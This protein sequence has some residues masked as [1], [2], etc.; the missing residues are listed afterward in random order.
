MKTCELM[1]CCHSR[2]A[3]YSCANDMVMG[4]TGAYCLLGQHPYRDGTSE[5]IHPRLL[6]DPLAGSGKWVSRTT[7]IIFLHQ[8]AL[9]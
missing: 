5:R 1:N 3:H 2:L 4:L 9:V 8:H 6:G 7:F